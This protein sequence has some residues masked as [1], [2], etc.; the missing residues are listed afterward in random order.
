[1][2]VVTTVIKPLDMETPGNYTSTGFVISKKHGLVLSNR[3]VVT[4][5]APSLQVAV[6]HNCKEVPI[7][8]IYRDPTHDF[9]VFRSNPHEAEAHRSRGNRAPARPCARVGED[10]KAVGN[11]AGEKLSVPRP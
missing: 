8:P 9:G 11:D 3:H 6:F 2:E 7:Y 10:I 5:P 1:M 4:P